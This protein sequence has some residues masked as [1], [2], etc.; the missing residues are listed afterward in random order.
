MPTRLQHSRSLAKSRSLKEHFVNALQQHLLKKTKE[1]LSK[2][3]IHTKL[4]LPL[5]NNINFPSEVLGSMCPISQLYTCIFPPKY[6][7]YNSSNVPLERT[8]KKKLF[9]YQTNFFSCINNVRRTLFNREI[10]RVTKR[11]RANILVK[12]RCETFHLGITLEAQFIWEEQTCWKKYR[13]LSKL[14]RQAD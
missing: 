2:H 3:I 8:K 11:F 4:A 5:S 10:F 13:C 1:T 14:F 12:F 9:K 7:V 6:K